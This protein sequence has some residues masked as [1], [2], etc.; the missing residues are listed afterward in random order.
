[1]VPSF[2]TTPAAFATTPYRP[3]MM[4][5]VASSEVPFITRPPLPPVL[6]PLLPNETP[7]P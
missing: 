1:M 6:L 5:A 4:L 2:S 7:T 3:P